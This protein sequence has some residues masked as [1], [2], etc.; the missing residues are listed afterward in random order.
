MEEAAKPQS[1]LFLWSPCLWGKLQNLACFAALTSPR[2][3]GELQNLSLCFSS[4]VAVSM[5]EAAKP[6]SLC[7]AHVAMSMR[8]AAKL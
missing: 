1:L 7:C 4:C 2:Q 8:E 6:R 3:S 5:E